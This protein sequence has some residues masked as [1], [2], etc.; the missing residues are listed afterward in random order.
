MNFSSAPVHDDRLPRHGS[1]IAAYL[2]LS[3]ELRTPANAILG[4]VELLLSGSAGP[5]T[6]EA[7]A[8][9]GDIQRAAVALSAQ[10]GRMISLAETVPAP[11]A[12]A[13]HTAS[14]TDA[15]PP[16]DADQQPA[17]GPTIIG[18]EGCRLPPAHLCK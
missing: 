16:A 4:H 17:V 5:L 18:G 3:H 13:Q 8:S 6:R 2:N 10:I 14:C 11:P 7:R 9:L 12:D 15:G 1:H